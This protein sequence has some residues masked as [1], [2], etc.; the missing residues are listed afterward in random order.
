MRRVGRATGRAFAG[1]MRRAWT[2][3]RGLAAFVQHE[4]V[5]YG[6]HGSAYVPVVAGGKVRPRG[7]NKGAGRGQG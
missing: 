2:R 4:F 6:L 5:R 7:R 3:E 1:A